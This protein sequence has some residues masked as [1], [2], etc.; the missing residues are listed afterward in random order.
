MALKGNDLFLVRERTQPH[1]SI[2]AHP[3]LG[4][5]STVNVL[6]G[7]ANFVIP[8]VLIARVGNFDPHAADHVIA[9]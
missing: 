3:A 6:W 7:F 2:Q 9:L 1:V 4:Q 8:Y 5:A